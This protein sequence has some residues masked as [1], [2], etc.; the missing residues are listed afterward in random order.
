MVR[1][2]KLIDSCFDRSLPAI[3]S[4]K[5]TLDQRLALCRQYG[6]FSLAY[7]T[8]VQPDLSYFGDEK[9]YIAYATKMGHVF[10]LGDPIASRASKAD[11][12]ARFIAQSGK[13]CFVQVHAAT[14]AALTSHGYR[15]NQL[16]KDSALSLPNHSFNGKR[17][18][19]LRYSERWLY[20]NGYTVH[21][22]GNGELGPELSKI[23]DD[24]RA[25]RIVKR[26]EM[27]FLNRPFC[28]SL[29]PG[30]RRFVLFSPHSKP[31]ALLDFDPLCRDGKVIGYT[32][33][34]KRKIQGTT[35]HAEIGLT[36]YAAD[37]FRQEG[38]EIMTLGL[39]PLAGI[40]KSQFP[41]ST[42][43]RYLY[44]RAFLSPL[45]NRRIFN[46]QGQAAFKRRFHGD[47]LQTY[48]GFKRGT[49]TEK[50]A[51]LRLLKTF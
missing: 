36:K 49:P 13:P 30:M 31:I 37:R 45:I 11:Y 38:A 6:D 29:R 1:M 17:N 27:R 14:A 46:V 33:A 22:C 44:Q 48:I 47:E 23:S 35:A 21:E 24:W 3:P 4:S 50:V 34:F 25:G 42:V 5:L 43:W 41:E 12:I 40:E 51:L 9:G 20:K 32:A 15:V 19:T 7:S 2:R 18:E 39:S 16:G 26:R 8:A 28:L 10:A